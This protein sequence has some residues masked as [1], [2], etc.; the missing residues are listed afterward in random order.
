[1]TSM[2]WAAR[3][4]LFKWFSAQSVTVVGRHD[5][6]STATDPTRDGFNFV[7]SIEEAFAILG[8]TCDTSRNWMN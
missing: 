1:M 3:R 6:H 8:T 2:D 7:L 5:S 4:L